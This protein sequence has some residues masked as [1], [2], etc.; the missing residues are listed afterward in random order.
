MMCIKHL[1][2]CREA[3]ENKTLSWQGMAVK[4]IGKMQKRSSTGAIRW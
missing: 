3:E 1:L 2:N 4:E